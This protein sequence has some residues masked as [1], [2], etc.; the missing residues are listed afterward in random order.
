MARYLLVEVDS[1]ATADR[2]R[3]Q[4]DNAGEAKG[5]RVVGM[6]TK[7]TQL[8]E[9]AEPVRSTIGNTIV[10]VRGAKRGWLICPRCA[11]PRSGAQQTLW[12]LLDVQLGTSMAYEVAHIGVAWVKNSLGVV[13]TRLKKN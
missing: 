4:L 10:D 13:T 7:A 11:K 6:F 3:A 5:I 1:N 2:M 12:N 9:C 8:C